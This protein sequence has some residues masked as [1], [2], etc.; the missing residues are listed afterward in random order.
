MSKHHHD[1]DFYEFCKARWP[2]CIL[3]NRRPVEQFH[4]F[5]LVGSP[6][7]RGPAP[8]RSSTYNAAGVCNTCHD[9]MHDVV[10]ERRV[11]EAFLGGYEELYRRQM[12]RLHEY[13]DY[14]RAGA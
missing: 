8:R 6:Y 11:I 9:A 12:R 4:H 10:G 2:R 7:Y 3:C 14:L 13:L 5:Q 1:A